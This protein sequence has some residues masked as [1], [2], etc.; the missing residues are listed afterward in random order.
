M[1]TPKKF[2]Q[3]EK[4]YSQALEYNEQGNWG[5]SETE[6]MKALILYTNLKAAEK[7]AACHYSI[8]NVCFNKGNLD[9]T[10]KH[11][12]EALELYKK[13]NHSE[14]GSVC[15]DLGDLMYDQKELY[16]SGHFYSQALQ[17]LERSPIGNEE[18]F[19][20]AHMKLGK[21]CYA[22]ER[23]PAAEQ[24]FLKAQPIL[25][26]HSREDLLADIFK[27]LG[28]IYLATNDLKIAKQ[29]FMKSFQMFSKIGH[30]DGKNEC[31]SCI[32]AIENK[33]KQRKLEKKS[34]KLEDQL[35]LLET[36]PNGLMPT[37]SSESEYLGELKTNASRDSEDYTPIR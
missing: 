15:I 11:W 7:V 19:G 26:K 25:E 6:F 5:L 36:L 32:T 31:A 13:M 33:E 14:A 27:C 9:E 2:K 34:K 28:H 24:H 16:G 1:S 8:G 35:K 22:Q 17:L 23:Y 4:L 20:I 21:V 10:R 37:E 29:N 12:E 18:N 3:A 30:E